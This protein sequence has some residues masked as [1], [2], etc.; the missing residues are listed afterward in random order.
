MKLEDL[1][2]SFLRGKGQLASVLL[3]A[4]SALFAVWIFV[5]LAGVF[6]IP[7]KAEQLIQDAM[8]RTELDEKEK[9]KYFAKSREIVEQLKKKNAFAPPAKKQHP[10]EQVTGILGDEV[11]IKDKWYKLGDRVADARIVA[12]EPAQVRIEW[13]GNEKV[14]APISSGS[15]SQSGPSGRTRP[16]RRG[17]EEP[18]RQ[19]AEMVVV[20][21]EQGQ[22]PGPAPTGG[23]QPPEERPRADAGSLSNMR[24][25]WESMSEEE[26]ERIRAEMRARRE[27]F[28]NMSEEERERFR[29]EMRER[30]GGEGP[31]R[32][33][34][35]GRGSG[36]SRGGR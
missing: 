13:E 7:A 30:Y 6:T 33:P 32:G 16:E 24:Q 35:G 14:F 21:S 10:V 29:A 34:G 15:S 23:Q 17:G 27:R 9:D 26:R 28:M 22:R 5:E 31:G 2:D 4:A 1:K 11:L 36:R 3:F 25:R 8:A 20:R 12:I 18:G 19:R